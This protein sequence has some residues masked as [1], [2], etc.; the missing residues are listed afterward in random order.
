M[1]ITKKYLQKIIE[2]E[3]NSNIGIFSER[4]VNI[5]ITKTLISEGTVDDIAKDEWQKDVEDCARGGICR[6]NP[7]LERNG[8]KF[9]HAVA[10]RKQDLKIMSR[11]MGANYEN[12]RAAAQGKTAIKNLFQEIV[13]QNPENPWVRDAVE[14]VFWGDYEVVGPENIPSKSA[15]GG[16]SIILKPDGEWT[17]EEI[18]TRRVEVLKSKVFKSLLAL[19]FARSRTS[20]GAQAQL[21]V[22]NKYHAFELGGGAAWMSAD[23]AQRL[24]SADLEFRFFWS[25]EIASG[26]N[27]GAGLADLLDQRVQTRALHQAADNGPSTKMTKTKTDIEKK[28]DA[29]LAKRGKRG[30][31]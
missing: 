30:K 26:S 3:V 17:T 8:E 23:P 2:E 28:R 21:Q 14:E 6:L 10:A 25:K 22:Y 13:E 11:D 7:D 15:V 29:E 4:K 18:A 9:K 12:N 31:E 19:F 27:G 20:M 1:K 24:S 16:F 5:N